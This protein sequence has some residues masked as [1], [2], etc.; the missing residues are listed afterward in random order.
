MS[1][2]LDT[3]YLLMSVL[4]SGVGAGFWVYGKKQ[5]SLV[6]LFGGIA[7]IAISWLI[8]SPLWMSVTAIGIIAAIWFF[9]R[10]E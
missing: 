2:N 10:M 7:L 3:G 8:T 5:R 6:P 9:S 4:W 1:F